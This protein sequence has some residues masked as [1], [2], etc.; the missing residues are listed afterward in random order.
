[1]ELQQHVERTTFLINFTREIFFT[2]TENAV[3]IFEKEKNKDFSIY[4]SSTKNWFETKFE[5][6]P[7][8]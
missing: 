5:N 4:L 3:S 2:D 8:C 7:I 1:M 6:D